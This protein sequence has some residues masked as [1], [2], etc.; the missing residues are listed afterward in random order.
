MEYIFLMVYNFKVHI[1]KYLGGLH[2]GLEKSVM[3]LRDPN[4]F[5][6]NYGNI[7]AVNQSMED[8]ISKPFSRGGRTG[9]DLLFPRC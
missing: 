9:S 5:S 8:G 1:G 4:V 3:I 7:P 6:F 2:T